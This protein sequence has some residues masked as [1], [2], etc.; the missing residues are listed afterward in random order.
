MKLQNIR[1]EN[2]L[3]ISDWKKQQALYKGSR[4][5][6]AL[7]FFIRVLKLEYH[8]AGLLILRNGYHPKSTAT[9]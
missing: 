7:Y 2:D 1:K 8:V 5:K 3:K 4:I 9:L 6:M